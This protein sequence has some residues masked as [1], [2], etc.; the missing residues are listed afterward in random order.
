MNIRILTLALLL[1]LSGFFYS[2]GENTAV[3]NAGDEI[4]YETEN[5]LSNV[6]AEVR[7]ESDELEREFRDARTNIDARM[8]ELERDMEGATEEA[9]MEMEEE[10]NELEAYRNDIDMRMERV[11]ANWEAGWND[12]EGDIN[13]GWKDFRRESDELLTNVERFFDPEGDLE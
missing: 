4:E 7:A 12:F 3:D 10:Y 5:A 1:S 11:G 9:R 13:Q 8:S 6:G 2:C